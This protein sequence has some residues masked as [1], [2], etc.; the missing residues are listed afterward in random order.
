MAESRIER[1]SMGEMAVPAAALWGAST[2]RAVLNFPVSGYRF[3]RR[4]IRALGLVKY[5]AAEANKR[6][7]KLDPHVGAL[8]QQAAREVIDGRLDDHFVLDI[9]QTGS[10]TST[11]MNANEVIARRTR[12]T[13]PTPTRTIPGSSLRGPCHWSGPDKALPGR[14]TTTTI[15]QALVRKLAFAAATLRTAMRPRLISAQG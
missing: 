4:F 8:I 9:F 5:A 10:G 1:D 13:S 12:K 14:L 6:L 7:G 15:H 11:N 3:G 2:Q